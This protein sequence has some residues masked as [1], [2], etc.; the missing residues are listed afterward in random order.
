VLL[1]VDQVTAGYRSG[2]D[3]LQGL[4]L[5]I[6]ENRTYCII[7][8]NGAGKSTLLKVIG[9]LLTARSGSIRFRDEEVTGLRPDQ[10]LGRGVCFVPQ[11][12]SLFPK[13]TVRQNL[14]MGAFL[15]DDKSV[16]RSRIEEAFGLFPVLA[17]KANQAAGTLSGGQQQMLLMGRALMIKPTMMMIDEPSLGLAPQAA[18]QIF[19]TIAGLSDLGITTLLVEQSVERGL[20]VSDWAFVLDLGQKRFE[21]PSDEILEDPRIGELYMGKAPRIE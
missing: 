21:G 14:V 15:E 17:E 1:H 12:P 2:P 3:I 10:L 11:D 9:G 6:E 18:D 19:E 13:M 5:D 7:G 20:N 8:P 16:V 4:S